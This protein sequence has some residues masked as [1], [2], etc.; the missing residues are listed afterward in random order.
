MNKGWYYF[1]LKKNLIFNIAL[2][3]YKNQKLKNFTNI[4]K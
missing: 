4:L 2:K 3:F 1:V